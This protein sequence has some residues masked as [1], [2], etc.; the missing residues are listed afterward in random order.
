MQPKKQRRTAGQDVFIKIYPRVS[1]KLHKLWNMQMCPKRCLGFLGCLFWFP[2][3]VCLLARCWFLKYF[4]NFLPRFCVEMESNLTFNHQVFVGNAPT[5]SRC[6]SQH[7]TVTRSRPRPASRRKPLR[8]GP[9]S[10]C[11]TFQ[12]RRSHYHILRPRREGWF[13]Q[14]KDCDFF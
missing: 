5:S 10:P 3:F 7:L 12:R 6:R 14:R 4:G 13:T 9:T 1:S 11:P 2:W 8:T